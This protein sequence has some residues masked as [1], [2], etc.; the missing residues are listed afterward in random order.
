MAARGGFRDIVEYLLAQDADL[1][2]SNELGLTAVDFARAQGHVP[3]ADFLAARLR[4]SKVPAS[5]RD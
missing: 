2:V 4:D 3:L 5:S 1:H